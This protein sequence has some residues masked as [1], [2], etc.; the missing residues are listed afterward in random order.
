MGVSGTE[1][2]G[3][4]AGYDYGG[5]GDECVSCGN[6]SSSIVGYSAGTSAEYS[7][8]GEVCRYASYVG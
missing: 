2:V 4:S 8:D 5:A 6:V 3:G 7:I 1:G